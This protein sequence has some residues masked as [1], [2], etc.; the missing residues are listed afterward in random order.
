MEAAASP[1]CPSCESTARPALIATLPLF[2]LLHA[3][4]CPDCLEV[5]VEDFGQDFAD[6]PEAEQA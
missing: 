6:R 2:R 3:F 1:G 5:W 4:E